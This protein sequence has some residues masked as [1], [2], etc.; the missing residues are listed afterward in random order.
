Q[1]VN[2][3][4]R[5]RKDHRS[6]MDGMIQLYA[7]YME[8]EEKRSMG[9]RMSGWDQK[10]LKYG[11]LFT[12]KMMDLSVNIPL[13]GALDSGWEILAECFTPEE[14]RMRTELVKEFWPDNS[15]N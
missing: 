13:E 12:S 14:T 3:D 8:T 10:L 1:N 9:F 7:Q 6:I 2:D 11:K 5:S 15:K 4:K